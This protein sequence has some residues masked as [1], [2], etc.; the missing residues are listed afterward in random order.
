MKDVEGAIQPLIDNDFCP[1][2]MHPGGGRQKLYDLAFYGY[3]IVV[4]Y[5]SLETTAEDISQLYPLR[6]GSP[7]PA[8]GGVSR[9]DAKPLTVAGDEVVV[10]VEGGILEGDYASE[11]QLGHQAI[12]EGAP[13]LRGIGKDEP[14][15]QL[16]HGSLKL[17]GFIITL[18][19]VHP[20]VAGGGKLGGPIQVK[21]CGEP[22]VPKDF[23]ADPKAAIQVFLF[24]E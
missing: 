8:K 4:G 21:A 7:G 2:E 18:L 19:H 1:H 23:H 10:E 24:L 13:G 15:A 11:A 3:G 17:S 16:L 22:M 5:G 9:G 12:L 20:S 6:Q 14:D